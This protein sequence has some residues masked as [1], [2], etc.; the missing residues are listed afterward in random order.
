LELTKEQLKIDPEKALEQLI[1]FIEETIPAKSIFYQ[2]IRRTEAEENR[3]KQQ[4]MNPL[5]KLYRRCIATLSTREEMKNQAKAI[6]LNIDPL[7]NFPHLL[8]F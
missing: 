3:L 1:R 7:I 5:G 6:I 2:G 4:I 8:N